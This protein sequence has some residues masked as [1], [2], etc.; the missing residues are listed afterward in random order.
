L[1]GHKPKKKAAP[2]AKGSSKV[3]DIMSLLK[4]SLDEEKKPKKGRKIA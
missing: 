3:H 4:A 1:K 2:A